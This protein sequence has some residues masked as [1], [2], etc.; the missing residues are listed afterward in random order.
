MKKTLLLLIVLLPLLGMAQRT[1]TV[2]ATGSAVGTDVVEVKKE[3]L[4]KAKVNAL[5]EAGVMEAVQSFTTTYLEA[6]DASITQNAA[7]ELGMLMLDGQVRLKGEPRYEV[8]PPNED[9]LM[10]ATVTIRAEVREEEPSDPEFRIKVGG[11]Q[12]TYRDGEQVRFAITPF[13]DCYIRIFWFDQARSAKVEGDMIYPMAKR[14]RDQLWKGDTE[15]RY[16][17]LPAEFLLG[18]PLKVEAYKQTDQL[19]ETTL[20]FV[21][22]LKKQIP[23]EREVCNYDQFIDWLLD[24]PA[25]QRTVYWRPIGIVK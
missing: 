15:Y 1:K 11:L 10:R 17:G 12:P 19:M 4:R 2:T 9:N 6:D 8:T 5:Q 7:A 16:P 14:Y 24:I 25:D 18:N 21:V 23:Y 3:A 13:R 20:L 22:A